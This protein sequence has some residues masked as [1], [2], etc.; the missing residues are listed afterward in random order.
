MTL[1]LIVNPKLLGHQQRQLR[2]R[3]PVASPSFSTLAVLVCTHPLR[4]R[5][6]STH[7][8]RRCLFGSPLCAAIGV[9]IRE[10]GASIVH[11][12][13]TSLFPRN[14]Y[15]AELFLH[16]EAA[17]AVQGFRPRASSMEFSILEGGLNST[18][19]DV[20]ENNSTKGNEQL[21][22]ND[23]VIQQGSK[24]VKLF[25][26][27]D[28]FLF[29]IRYLGHRNFM[30][31]MQRKLGSQEHK[32]RQDEEESKIPINQYIH[33]NREAYWESRVKAATRANRI[34]AMRC[35]ARMYVMLDKE[36]ESWIVSRLELRHSHPYSAKKSIHYHEYRELTMHAKSSLRIT[37]RSNKTYLALVNEVGGSSNLSFSEK[38]VKNYITNKLRCADENAY[39]KEMMNYF[40]RMK[41][42]NLNFFYAIDA[43]EANKFRSALWIDARCRVSYEYYRNVM[44]FDTSTE[45]I[46]MYTNGSIVKA[47]MHG[48][49]FASFINVNHHGKSTLLGCALL[50]NEEILSEIREN[51]TKGIITDQCKAMAGAIRKVQPNTVHRWCIWH[52]LKKILAK[53][54]GYAW[55]IK[56]NAKMSHIVRNSPFMDSFDGTLDVVILLCLSQTLLLTFMPID[57]SGFQYSLR[58]SESMH[59]FYG[60]FLFC[61][62]GLVQFV[63]EYDNVLGNKEQKEL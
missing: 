39:F 24:Q 16:K 44:S 36:K 55:Y 50:E 1:N 61:K 45:E 21:N 3:N 62:G 10:L 41:E 46:G 43:D 34:T 60:R 42:I 59:P 9:A 17:I 15:H 38:D 51:C 47:F 8:L 33:Y 12:S 7:T 11:E 56:L 30:Q 63:H 6:P 35:R 53:L 32:F 2:S 29:L 31:I 23:V 58:R 13:I 49:L 57:E 14:D 27:H 25:P 40:M 4:P 37:T 26:T 28:F 19:I 22:V 5:S 52:I 18:L 20:H 48:L 54:R